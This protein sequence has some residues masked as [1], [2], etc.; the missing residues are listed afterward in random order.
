MPFVHPIKRFVG[1]KEE[2]KKVLKL[3]RGPSV[4][5]DA[6]ITRYITSAA[7]APSVG[8]WRRLLE[9]DAFTPIMITMTLFILTFSSGKATRPGFRWKSLAHINRIRHMTV[10]ILFV[11]CFVS[12]C[13]QAAQSWL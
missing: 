12:S 8:K 5:V 13:P 1:K 7:S 10:I 4:D 9:P 3:F 2:A 6:E 11:Y